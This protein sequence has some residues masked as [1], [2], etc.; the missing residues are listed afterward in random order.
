MRE[1]RLAAGNALRPCLHPAP[2]SEGRARLDRFDDYSSRGKRGRAGNAL[3]P[4]LRLW[5]SS[6][7]RARLIP[8]GDCL[9]RK[10]KR[11]STKRSRLP[12]MSALRPP[13]HP[14]PSRGRRQLSNSIQIARS[15]IRPLRSKPSRGRP[16]LKNSMLPALRALP[17]CLR[18]GPNSTR[19][20]LSI[21]FGDYFGR[22]NRTMRRQTVKASPPCFRMEPSPHPWIPFGD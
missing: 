16:P 11:R 19:R 8:F 2:S 10:K 22:R 13:L 1:L 18:A 9:N 4:R 21:P 15:A 12:A 5:A 7:S 20:R 6:G 3:H 17:P 14:G